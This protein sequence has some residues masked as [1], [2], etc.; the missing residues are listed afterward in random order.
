MV[1]TGFKQTEVGEIP[2]DW[3]MVRL[4]DHS[5]ITKLA[6]FEYTNYFN[7]YKDGGDIIVVRG[8][9][10]TNNRLDLSDLRT[11]PLS[12]S[13]K[14]PRSQLGRGD[15]VFAYVGTIGPVYLVEDDGRFHLGP[16]TAKITC[17]TDLDAN[18][19]LAY[20][21]SEFIRSE[22]EENT[23]TGA[24]ASLSMSKIR[25]FRII[26]PDI[27]E[28]AAIAKALS[29]IDHL[30]GS[31]EEVIRKKRDIKTAT[32][33]QLLTGKK[34]LPDFGEKK[35]MKETELGKIPEDWNIQ[36]LGQVATVKMGHSPSSRF[37]NRQ[38]KGVPLIQ[39]N[40]DV[41][42]RKTIARTY[43]TETTKHAVKGDIL[44]SV[45]APVGE[46]A[47]ATFNCCIGRGVCSVSYENS[48]LYHLLIFLENT[49]SKYSSGSTFYA[50]SS[51]IVRRYPLILPSD[52]KEQIAIA[53]V[54]SDM[55]ADI[56]HL[57]ARLAKIK[58]VKQGMMQEL[59]TGRTRLI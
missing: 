19:L 49:W 8:T 25:N 47:L 15:I 24:Q 59:L 41:F 26:R 6:G 5:F 42:E 53:N 55:N 3:E 29:N 46:V 27:I 14:L 34:R 33:Q 22:I 21:K 4:G 44:L 43:T 51:D 56:D 50:V 39:G 23:S 11:I 36:E 28:Q 18:Y 52:L 40:A 32:M 17:N 35:R 30:I 54:L 31:L 20:F 38:G 57:C 2:E 16:N 45:R 48:Y 7:N 37:Y 9:N 12:T 58:T 10:I 13:Q 1:R